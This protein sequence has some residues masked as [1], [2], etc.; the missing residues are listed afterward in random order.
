MNEQYLELNRKN[1]DNRVEHHLDSDFYQM[2]AF[3]A[4]ETSLK[5]IELAYPFLISLI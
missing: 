5:E 3:R 4:G 1:W 2:D